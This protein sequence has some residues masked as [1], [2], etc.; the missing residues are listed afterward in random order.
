[1]KRTLPASH[2]KSNQRQRA[3]RLTNDFKLR[4]ADL[5]DVDE[6]V[7]LHM[8]SLS[9]GIMPKIG[10]SLLKRYYQIILEKQ[11][12]NLAWST[13]VFHNEKIIGFI[14]IL[15]E[16]ISLLSLLNF[17][18]ILKAIRLTLLKPGYMIV[19]LNAN[20][21]KKTPLKVGKCFELSSFV[22]A[23][24]Y[25]GCGLGKS[26]VVSSNEWS[27][28]RGATEVYTYTHNEGLVN[29]YKRVFEAKLETR[30][31]LVKYVS[32]RVYWRLK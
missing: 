29:F 24:Q 4:S 1:M 30:T 15:T 23:E 6:I 9:V 8:R 16:P 18:D 19:G 21:Q 31:N 10:A 32:H 20:F 27:K 17:A 22:V 13:C 12:Q 2:P 5:K 28:S 3:D 7:E 25:R 11:K 26:L 14:F